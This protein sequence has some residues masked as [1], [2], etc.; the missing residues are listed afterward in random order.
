MLLINRFNQSPGLTWGFFL[1]VRNPLPPRVIGPKRPK[2][3]PE[4]E[5]RPFQP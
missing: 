3:C 1:P 4:A 5:R 2:K